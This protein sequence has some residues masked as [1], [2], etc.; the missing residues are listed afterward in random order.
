MPQLTRSR[1]VLLAF[2]LAALGLSV[3]PLLVRWW[4]VQDA[5]PRVTVADG[6][7]SD[8]MFWR[9]QE[10]QCGGT[11][12]TVWQVHISA[13]NTQPRLAFDAQNAPRPL[14]VEQIKGGIVIRLDQP[15]AGSTES[16]VSIPVVP[17]MRPKRILHFINGHQRD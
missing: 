2:G 6:Y 5:C 14:S 4:A 17:K 15:P 16:S 7:F 8:G 11:I 9:I 13:S 10:A 12:G 3:A 1:A